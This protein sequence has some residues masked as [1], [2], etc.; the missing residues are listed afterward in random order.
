[1]FATFVLEADGG[2]AGWDEGDRRLAEDIAQQLGAAIQDA[3]AHS[4]TQKALEEMRE[5]DRLKTQFLANISHELRTPLNSIIGFSRVILKGIDGPITELQDQ[6]LTAIYNAGLHLLGLI[7]DILDLSKIEA[8]KMELALGEV[9]IR[10]VI[11]NVMA[12]AEGLVKDRP[13]ELL[14]DVPEGLP[15]LQADNLRVRQILLNL[16]SNA[17]K[18]TERGRIGVSARLQGA[19]GQEEILVSVSDTGPGI[20]IDDQ[21]KL[22]EPFSQVDASPARKTGG[23]GLGL[24]ICRHLVELHGGRIWVESSVGRGSTFS[25]SLP[26]RPPAPAPA[27]PQKARG[28]A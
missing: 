24:S 27:A 4:L 13:I 22:F 26:L 17:A 21:A 23:T 18:F 28:A 11:R 7:N 14:I 5:A 20:E 1:L 19:V 3:R 9:D 2:R 15:V 10:E 12:T 6:D 25:F 16:I 8:R